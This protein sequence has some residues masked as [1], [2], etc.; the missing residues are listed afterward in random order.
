MIKRILV[1][2]ADPTY[3]VSATHHAV[4]LAK[5]CSG[6]LTGV[7]ILDA[8][9]LRNI[10][11]VTAGVENYATEIRAQRFAQADNSISRSVDAFSRLA[12]EAGISYEVVQENGEPFQHFIQLSRYHD[13]VV[14]GLHRLFEHGVLTEPPNELIKL[15]S[16]GVRPMVATGPVYRETKRVLIAYSGSVES[17]KT[18]RHFTQLHE[19]WPDISVKIVSF[20]SR[21]SQDSSHLTDAQEYIQAHGVE[22]E[23]EFIDDSPR[24][25]LLQ[26]ADDWNADMI[27][28]GNSAKNILMRRAFGDTALYTIR[29]SEIPLFLSQ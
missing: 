7:S 29:E 26:F 24:V 17:A 11:T 5:R 16:A 19:L 4:E 25:R 18:M 28:M 22:S 21:H 2:I 20:R 3:T 14:C 9:R 27:V 13:L 8:D 15:I 23:I 10:G 12:D 1:G 6:T